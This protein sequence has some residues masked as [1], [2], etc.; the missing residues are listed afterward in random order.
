[1]YSIIVPHRN[2][3][4]L[5][6]SI[7]VYSINEIM[8]KIIFSFNIKIFLKRKTEMMINR[9][10]LFN[11]ININQSWSTSDVRCKG[12]LLLLKKIFSVKAFRSTV[13]YKNNMRHF[14]SYKWFFRKPSYNFYDASKNSEMLLPVQT[15]AFINNLWCS[16]VSK[17][18]LSQ[19]SV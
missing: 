5:A 2:S 11:T 14:R 18:V 15:Y 4:F 13:S 16:I 9:C 12:K 19:I 7:K 6:W 17:S 8:S 3:L 1:M 10:V